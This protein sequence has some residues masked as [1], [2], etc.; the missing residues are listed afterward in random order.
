MATRFS[1]LWCIVFGHDDL[2]AA[3]PDRLFL[4][5]RTCGRTSPGW[6]VSRYGAPRPAPTNGTAATETAVRDRSDPALPRQPA[7]PVAATSKGGAAPDAGRTWRASSTLLRLLRMPILVIRRD[8]GRG[9]TRVTIR[10][11]GP[12]LTRD[13]QSRTPPL[14]RRPA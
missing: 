5:C 9:S 7:V 12:T 3:L 1:V 4:V 6:S 13:A 10:Y 14:A 2:V 8:A 11:I